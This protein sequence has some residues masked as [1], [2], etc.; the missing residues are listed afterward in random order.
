MPPWLRLAW[1]EFCLPFRYKK[2]GCPGGRDFV[3]LTIFLTLLLS[4]ILLLWA[5]REGMLNRF[6]DVLLGNVPGYGVPVSVTNNMLSKGG[7]NAIDSSVLA[8]VKDLKQEV[9]GLQVFPYRS[10]EAASH[11]L[12]ALPAENV[13]ENKHNGSKFGPDFDGWAVYFDDPLWQ[14]DA[15]QAL[16]MEIV[17]SR[18]LFADYFNYGA[19][20][21]SLREMLPQPLFDELPAYFKVTDKTINALRSEQMPG[22]LVAALAS[23]QGEEFDS[24]SAFLQALSTTLGPAQANQYRQRIM[25]DAT[26]PTL[27]ENS[28]LPLDFIWLQVHV[29]FSRE[30]F[31][32]SITWVERFPV[33]DKISFVFPL[34][35]Y[36]ALKAAHDFPELRY[37]P[38]GG[39]AGGQRYQQVMLELP[40][41]QDEDAFL[42]RARTFAEALGGE[43]SDY[44][45]DLLVQFK[46]PYR[47]E[48]LDAYSRQ[49]DLNY[50]SVNTVP[51]DRVEFQAAKL[52]L[53]C[54]R[55]PDENLREANFTECGGDRQQMLALDITAE[56]NGFRYALVYVPD[57]TYLGG[58]VERLKQVQD[59]A[60]TIHSAY[61]DALNR[62]SFLSEML[63][64]M[65]QPYS[66][67]LAVFLLAFLGVQVGT[68]IGHHR[69]RYGVFLS[70]GMEWWQIYAMLWVQ[71]TLAMALSMGV[72]WLAM[73]SARLYLQWVIAPVANHYAATLSIVDLNLLPLNAGEFWGA[74]VGVVLFAWGL[75]ALILYHLPLRH[76]THP[77]RLL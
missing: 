18:S 7:L 30:I 71:I 24:E 16:P 44:R 50:R 48:L 17:M 15:T 67:F 42:E 74:S 8:A 52:S 21:N 49:Y 75:A 4:L 69:H 47:I 40:A 45:G 3:W 13:W 27:D 53:P 64:A 6:V 29:G 25:R 70:K 23:L 38:E 22:E 61:Q 43:M 46:H 73:S 39:G 41:D 56:G 58:A 5:S 55:L 68:L 62:F 28:T 32:C 33:I 72:A 1:K 63:A 9:P 26:F 57:R 2:S 34:S 19:Y 12:V 54:G 20:R 14:G 37:F 51:G 11:P 60:L 31:K 36:Q 10:L 35:T 59:Q 76:H 66:W 77:A 65:E